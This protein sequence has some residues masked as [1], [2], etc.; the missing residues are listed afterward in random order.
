MQQENKNNKKKMLNINSN[1]EKEKKRNHIISQKI[2]KRYIFLTK[3]S[4]ILIKPGK[5]KSK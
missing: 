3:S 2:K 5:S 4:G 1:Q